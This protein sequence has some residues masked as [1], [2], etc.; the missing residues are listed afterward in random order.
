MYSFIKR[1]KKSRLEHSNKESLTTKVK[2]RPFSE[3]V[4]DMM[5][6]GQMV[7]ASQIG[8]DFQADEKLP[9]IINVRNVRHMDITERLEA[10]RAINTRINDFVINKVKSAQE[11]REKV[12]SEANN[13]SPRDETEERVELP[14]ET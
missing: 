1:P 6:R 5:L 8:Y 9:E 3:N 12:P 2:V 4:V 10:L 14:L 7:H 11:Q 13:G